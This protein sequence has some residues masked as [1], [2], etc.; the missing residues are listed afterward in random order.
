MNGP[1]EHRPQWPLQVLTGGLAAG[2]AA[3]VMI[4]QSDW[5]TAV[6]V[7][8]SG[9][10]AFGLG[11]LLRKRPEP[12]KADLTLSGAV[13][14]GFDADS[15]SGL[16]VQF[17]SM[18]RDWLPTL[19][20][21]LTTANRQMEDGI[22]CLTEAFGGLHQQLNGIVSQASE[23]VNVLGGTTHHEGGLAV[24]V[25]RE[26]D[27]M[28]TQ[29]RSSMQDKLSL[30]N[31]VRGFINSTDELA[32]MA[33]SVEK[34]AAKTNLLALNAAIEAARAGE[35]GRG[36]SIVA[37]EVRKLS[38]LSADTGVRIRER[39]QAISQAAK[40]ASDGAGRIQASDE[41]LLGNAEHTVERVVQQFDLAAKPLKKVSEDIV[42]STRRV[43]GSLNDAVVHFQF[44]DRVSQILGHVQTSLGVL[45]TQLEQGPQFLN[46][47]VLLEELRRNY[48]MA[49]E[50]INH[51]QAE[52][53]GSAKASDDLTFF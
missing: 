39:V 41:S 23:A 42:A 14:D 25:S 31:E 30:M 40:N 32:R 47:S 51:G 46:A 5:I 36:F 6:G 11:F 48:T 9:L 12:A 3:S 4:N 15:V 34:L 37:D 45:K 35:N 17:Q 53:E 7:T 27:N 38:M 10:A 18:S 1:V 49:E 28:L 20:V 22:V 19:N 8:V 13:P 33:E 50:R 2:A 43:S 16:P 24:S 21:Q 44:Q 26:L 52:S 29:I